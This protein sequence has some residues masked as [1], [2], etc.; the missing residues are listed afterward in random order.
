M[1]Q[2]ECGMRSTKC[3]ITSHSVLRIL[4]SVAWL[5]LDDDDNDPARLLRYVVAALQTVA[6]QIG[7]A[8]SVLLQA[9]NCRPYQPC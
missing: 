8:L 6:P 1:D 9:P 5:S 3:G 2:C 4:H 7:A